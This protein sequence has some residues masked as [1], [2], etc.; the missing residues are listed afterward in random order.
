MKKNITIQKR[1]KNCSI[2]KINN[3][4]IKSLKNK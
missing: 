2:K 3:K 4:I 1:R